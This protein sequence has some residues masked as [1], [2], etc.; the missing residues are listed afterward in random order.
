MKKVMITKRQKHCTANYLK[1]EEVE[2]KDAAKR[3]LVFVQQV[4]TT[5]NLK[6][7]RAQTSIQCLNSYL[8]LHDEF[9][10]STITTRSIMEMETS[11]IK[12]LMRTVRF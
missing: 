8:D 3:L 1:Y 2:M 11:T 9:A 12:I 4:K 5:L 6:F 10:A 7:R